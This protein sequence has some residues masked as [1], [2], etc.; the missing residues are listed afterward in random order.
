MV[1][2][3]SVAVLAAVLLALPQEPAPPA[4]SSGNL[5]LRGG[6]VHTGTNRDWPGPIAARAGRIV[7]GDRL[8]PAID[9]EAI[10]LPDGAFVVP[11]LIDA[12]GH[13]KGLGDALAEVDLVGTASYVE[14]VEKVLAAAARAPKGAWILGRGWDQND[15]PDKAM[16]Q[17]GPLSAAVPDHPVWLVRVDGHAGLANAAAMA[18]SGITKDSATGQGG[19]I[20]RD[21]AGAPTGVLVDDAMALVVVPPSTDEQ[22]RERLLAAH[23]ACLRAGL[24]GVHDAGVDART[25]AAMVGLHKEGK[26]RLRVHVMLDPREDLLIARGPWQTDDGVIVVRA[27]KAYA[28]G[29]LGSHGAV[30]L[31]PYADRKGWKGLMLMPKPA[32]AALAQR[33]ADAG[34]QLCM[35]AIGDAANRAVLDAYATVQCEGGLAARRF[36]VEH[37]QIVADGDFARFAALGVVPSMQPTHLTSDMPWAPGRLG[38]ER[39]LRSYAWSRFHRL[40]V[41]VPF[42]SDFPV[43]SVDPRKGLFAAITT[44]GERGGGDGSLRR[45]QKLSREQALRGFTL[46]AAHAMFAERDLGTIEAG[47]SADFTVFDRDLRVCPEE[48]IL[49]AKVL[50][51]VVRGRVAW[52]AAGR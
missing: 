40:G 35:H 42:G 25:L 8:D 26:W 22:L 12:H 2:A 28:D 6:A 51:T 38:A 27:V 13:L 41:V 29:A 31:E 3:A 23:D 47:K 17:H 19:E 21:A 37:A 4:A 20:Q 43:E 16:P 11:G 24:V 9:A 1:A 52:S 34:M 36:R 39:T 45:D 15:W 44:R 46:H 50:M 32:L 5:L 14:V 33:C 49:Q 18:R 10:D 48:E 7:A 30:L